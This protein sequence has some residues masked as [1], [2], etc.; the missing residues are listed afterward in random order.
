MTWANLREI[1]FGMC[2]TVPFSKTKLT[3]ASSCVGQRSDIFSAVANVLRLG[4]TSEPGAPVISLS[5]DR[6]NGM[7]K[8]FYKLAFGTCLG[9]SSH[10]LHRG[11][12][13]AMVAAGVPEEVIMRHGRWTFRAWREYIDLTAAQLAATR[14]LQRVPTS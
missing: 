6:F 14:A 5:C 8:H 7:L 1:H 12:T 10:S 9:V 3:P 4:G 11:G 13:S 2:I